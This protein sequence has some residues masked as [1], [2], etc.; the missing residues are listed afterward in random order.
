[1]QAEAGCCFLHSLFVEFILVLGIWCDD[2]EMPFLFHFSH[3]TFLLLM[4]T[5]ILLFHVTLLHI[6]TPSSSSRH[7]C[8]VHIL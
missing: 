8:H 7:F 1:M 5:S 6:C 3:P 2:L 4:S